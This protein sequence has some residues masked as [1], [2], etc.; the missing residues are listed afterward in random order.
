MRRCRV[1]WHRRQSS[2]CHRVSIGHTVCCQPRSRIGG[3]TIRPSGRRPGLVLSG[4]GVGGQAAPQRV[5]NAIVNTHEG[6]KDDTSLVVVDIMP[7]GKQFSECTSGR[8]GSVGGCLCMCG[9][10]PRPDHRALCVTSDSN[11]VSSVL[12]PAGICRSCD[13]MTYWY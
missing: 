7:P 12:L 10:S 13:W 3:D 2:A 8:F 6:L 5:I 4:L 9:T 11:E 1:C